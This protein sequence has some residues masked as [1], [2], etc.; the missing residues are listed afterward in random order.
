M[1]DKD[2]EMFWQSFSRGES[3]NK[4]PWNMCQVIVTI[5]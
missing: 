4:F 3:I 2:S 1:K 5:V